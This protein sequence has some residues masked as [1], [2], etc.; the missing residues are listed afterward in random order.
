MPLSTLGVVPSESGG[1]FIWTPSSSKLTLSTCWV[2]SYNYCCFTATAAKSLQSC[3]TLCDPI[4]GILQARTLEWVAI[5]FSNAWKRKGR[6]KSPV[7]SNSSRPHGLQPTRLLRPWDFP[8]KIT[9]V[10]CRCLLVGIFCLVLGVWFLCFLFALSPA[11]TE[12][13]NFIASERVY[14]AKVYAH[15]TYF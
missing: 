14:N 7:V 8:G 11:L 1:A 9:R 4:P 15:P 3:P 10:G 12:N 6:V 5:S 2:F 13:I